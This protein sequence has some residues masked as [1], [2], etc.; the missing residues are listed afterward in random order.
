M[1]TL[2]P[3]EYTVAWLCALPG[4]ELVVAIKMLDREYEAPRL[5]NQ[6]D[7][8]TYTYGSIGGHNVV[9]ACL[10]P[11]QPGTQSALS[12]VQPLSQS[13]SNLSTHLFIGTG[14]GVPRNP[15]PAE[16]E[17]DIHLGD[18]V[19]GWA[20]AG[21]PGVVQW[22][23]VR[24]HGPERAEPLGILNKPDR[25]LVAALGPMISDSVIG[26]N[27]F[28][29]HL[30]RLSALGAFSHPGIRHDK[31]FVSSY[32]HSG[33]SSEADPCHRCKDSQLKNR[34]P[35]RSARPVFHQ[36]TIAS[37]NSMM[38]NAEQRDRV[39]RQFHDA[40]CFEMEAAGVTDET[41]CLVIRGI[42]NYAD[43]HKS[44]LWQ[45]YAAAAAASF[46]RKFLLILPPA[47]VVNLGLSDRSNSKF[48]L[49][50][51]YMLDV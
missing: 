4:S 19:V 20:D 28:S 27:H 6:Y 39:S 48:S 5:G 1:V 24:Y 43:S 13:F 34:P 37:G 2:R 30:G 47:L 46:A 29:E 36:G 45:N 9:I 15:P 26:R 32:K 44:F 8:N 17:N 42:S 51:I 35:R 31:L 16:P 41:Q 23:F 25:R 11:G 38:R 33:G 7:K 50:L 18:V 14:G 40:I 3:E 22:D 21:Y 10:P 12:L 49:A